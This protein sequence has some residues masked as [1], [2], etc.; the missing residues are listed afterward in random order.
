MVDVDDLAELD[1]VATIGGG[2][3][4]AV[5]F[6][7]DLR[8]GGLDHELVRDIIIGDCLL[9]LVIAV[10][11]VDNAARRWLPPIRRE[12]APWAVMGVFSVLGQ[13]Q[14]PLLVSPR[15]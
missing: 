13:R 14:P 8:D 15:R 10:L 12:V 4:R 5:L 3:S 7:A 11:L 6:L 9:E 1:D 2:R